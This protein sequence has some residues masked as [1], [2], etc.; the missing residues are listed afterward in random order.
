MEILLKELDL[1]FPKEEALHLPLVWEEGIR[2][3][4]SNT[5]VV[6]LSQCQTSKYSNNAKITRKK[7]NIDARRQ[8]LVR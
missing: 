1:I 6:Y 2:I 8:S 3:K 7:K 5:A 4:Y